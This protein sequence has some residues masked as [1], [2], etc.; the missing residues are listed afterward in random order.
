M[1]LSLLFICSFVRS[2]ARVPHLAILL[3]IFDALLKFTFAFVRITGFE[4]DYDSII[5][6][7]VEAAPNNNSVFVEGDKNVLCTLYSTAAC[8]KS[9]RSDILI[10]QK[11]KTNLSKSGN[12]NYQRFPRVNCTVHIRSYAYI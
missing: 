7:V 2:Y 11:S 4:H 6:L 12:T 9:Y 8:R 1:R 3:K 5:F 10:F